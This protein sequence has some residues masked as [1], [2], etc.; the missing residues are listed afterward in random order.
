MSNRS[1][2]KDI[3][4]LVSIMRNNSLHLFSTVQFNIV[5]V[6]GKTVLLRKIGSTIISRIFY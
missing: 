1:G 2:F 5:K 4:R 3:S 6:G